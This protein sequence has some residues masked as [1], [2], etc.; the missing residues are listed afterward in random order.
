MSEEFLHYIW[1]YGLY[2]SSDLLTTCGKRIKV[3]NPGH[4]NMDAGPDFLEAKL[5]ID[6][7]IWVGHVEIHVY[8]SDWYHHKHQLDP[9]YDPV[10]LHAVKHSD[11]QVSNSA[12]LF[13]PTTEL[14]FKPEF[15]SRYQ[16]LL[17][18]LNP[19]PC[20]SKWQDLSP[21]KV[22][23]AIIAM[24]IE[25]LEERMKGLAVKLKENRGGWKELFLQTI[26]RGFGFGKNQHPM[27]T[28]GRSIKPLWVEKHH[29]N[30]FQLESIFFG[31]AGLLPERS[32]DQYLTAL[33]TEYN[34]LKR[35]YNM[36]QPVG[37]G[38]KY[39]R[40]R[41]GN[42]PTLRIAQLCSFLHNK[43]DLVER[44]LNIVSLPAISGIEVRPSSYWQNHFDMGKK[45]PA[46]IPP[47]GESSKLLLMINVFLP[48]N[49]FYN[50]QKGE[51]DAIEAWLDQLE[52]LPAENNRVIRQWKE[53]GFRVP[54]AFY[55]QSFFYIYRSYCT[56]K[57]CLV[58]RIGQLI[59][60]SEK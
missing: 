46:I 57:K 38:W 30:L 34:Y 24:G 50:F 43:Q 4:Y 16:Q 41:P 52:K 23:N 36:I 31:Q 26:C 53:L 32:R 47:M 49:G 56:K 44:S 12:G 17:T 33:H 11:R 28:L 19:I 59:L 3:V 25:R 18:E 2:S 45:S 51:K 58:C 29:S 1:K 20:G 40:M 6:N 13:I 37:L 39:L 21:V 7:V 42:F 15:Y 5:V 27:E 48:L 8:A 35:K 22:E 9:A 55:S 60:G 14:K 54:N 10:I